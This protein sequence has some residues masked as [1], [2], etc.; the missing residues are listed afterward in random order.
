MGIS[1]KC[2]KAGTWP[3][4]CFPFILMLT[5]YILFRLVHQYLLYVLLQQS[6]NRGLRALFCCEIV[7]FEE[8]RPSELELGGFILSLHLYDRKTR[9]NYM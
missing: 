9:M 2:V 6:P 7:W 3:K 5:I 8:L 4:L 1:R